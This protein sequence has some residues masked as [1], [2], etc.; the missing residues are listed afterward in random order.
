[1]RTA[2]PPSE[3]AGFDGA[4]YASSRSP[5]HSAEQLAVLDQDRI[6][7]GIGAACQLGPAAAMGP[8]EGVDEVE[9]ERPAS[10]RSLARMVESERDLERRVTGIWIDRQASQLQDLD[11]AAGSRIDRA[12]PRARVDV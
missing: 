1:M 10:E 3:V 5:G 6:R 12:R 11:D 4:G 2:R 7:T 8:G 9:A